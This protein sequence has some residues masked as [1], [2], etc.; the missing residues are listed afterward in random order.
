MSSWH[1]Y[2][3]PHYTAGFYELRCYLMSKRLYNYSLLIVWNMDA[4]CFLNI[5]LYIDLKVLLDVWI[6]FARLDPQKKVG[7]IYFT[8]C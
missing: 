2:R 7:L 6:D 4:V 1:T 5:P 8:L 3:T